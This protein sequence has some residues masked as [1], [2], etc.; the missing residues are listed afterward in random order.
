MDAKEGC[1]I[2]FFN[3]DLK[4]GAFSTCVICE[5]LKLCPRCSIIEELPICLECK[6]SQLNA[7]EN[8][9]KQKL[10]PCCKCESV[11][12]THVCQECK[13]RYCSECDI[14]YAHVCIR[15]SVSECTRPSVPKKTCCGKRW[16]HVCI[17]RHQTT[18]CERT[19]FR[20][21]I[22]CKGKV[23]LFGP[24]EFKCPVVDCHLKYGCPTCC[25]LARYKR[26]GI[27]CHYHT[28]PGNCPGCHSPYPLDSALGYGYV[29]ILILLGNRTHKREHCGECLSKIR[30][31]VENSLIIIRRLKLVFPKVL[32]D[33]IVLFALSIL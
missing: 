13:N 24:D 3:L 1:S 25:I 15:C 6:H 5:R 23:L 29:K 11:W 21:C 16:C 30:A 7:Q 2:C 4:N 18:D 9:K 8:K 32:M 31:L 28:S 27:Y 26:R 20:I 10:D 22:Q 12:Q 33:K 19:L 17:S 14:P